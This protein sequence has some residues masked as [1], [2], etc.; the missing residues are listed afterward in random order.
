MLQVRANIEEAQQKQKKDHAKRVG[1]G[2]KTFYFQE[3]DL[4]EKK[5]MRREGRK[6]DTLQAIWTGKYR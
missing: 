6:G 1:K 5:N 3:G 2:V 4:V